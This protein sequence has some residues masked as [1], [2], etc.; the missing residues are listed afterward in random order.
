MP[1]KQPNQQR[2]TQ[3]A[4]DNSS[5]VFHAVN[6]KYSLFSSNTFFTVEMNHRC[7]PRLALSIKVCRQIVFVVA[8]TFVILI[9]IHLAKVTEV[10]FVKANV[11]KVAEMTVFA[12]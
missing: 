11:H 8:S 7:R 9:V 3:S 4:Q 10:S 1:F 6:T 12:A 5:T 2:P